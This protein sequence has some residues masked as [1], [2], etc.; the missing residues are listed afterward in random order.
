MSGSP[1]D[2]SA[3]AGQGDP[4]DR[5]S[6]RIEGLGAL[7]WLTRVR[8]RAGVR[9]RL[10]QMRS[11]KR[12]LLTVLGVAF[13]GLA[14]AAQVAARDARVS[15]DFVPLLA[16]AFLVAFPCLMAWQ[17][18]RQGVIHFK[19]EE[20]Q[21]L[22]PAPI[23][24]RALVVMN[25]LNRLGRVL[26]LSL[27]I[28]FFA[29]P[30]G[31]GYLQAA[32]CYSLLLSTASVMQIW[33]DVRLIG[34]PAEVRRR[35]SNWLG[36]L[37][38]LG[39]AASIFAA[40]HADDRVV[41]PQILR[42][43]VAPAAPFVAILTGR[44]PLAHPGAL[45]ALSAV[46]ALL[47]FAAT[48]VRV[49]IREA[50]HATSARMQRKLSRLAK[51][52]LAGAPRASTSGRLLPMP[53]HLGGAGPHIWRQLTALSRSKRP[54]VSIIIFAIYMAVVLF[55][56]RGGE[57]DAVTLARF[58]AIIG[59][60]MVTMTGPMYIQADF[61][62]DYDL[63]PW[64]R[65]LPTP[66]GWLAAGQL[67]GSVLVMFAL[68]LLLGGWILFVVPASEIPRWLGALAVLPAFDLILLS[69]WNGAFLL[70]PVRMTNPGKMMG[71]GQ[72]MRMYL[73]FFV[74]MLVVL[75]AVAVAAVMGLAAGWIA[76]AAS[77]QALAGY[78]AG[79][80]V[81]YAA[82]VAV[83]AVCVWLVGRIF[84]RVDPSRDLIA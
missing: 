76:R 71:F 22:F 12:A 80:I 4:A 21:F 83:A 74:V 72:A 7:W 16:G 17:A 45:A 49:D 27:A 25:V 52:S 47:V 28:S 10:H 60:G 24:T 44:T 14:I 66:P 63:L 6:Q 53:P 56:T 81:G 77:G 75:A 20:I 34:L 37:L 78:V 13:F 2:P 5:P 82:L 15:T 9:R 11:P 79:G 55:F 84:I 58:G 29:R 3:A 26:G 23:T 51:G 36:L 68:Q 38:L 57:H 65:T 1:H 59:L 30:V 43:F 67:L 61:R 31:V 19:P 48:R 35:R 50:A 64:L 62:S 32:L 33:I 46:L 8:L 40:W 42:Y 18:T 54:F 70:Y 73:V 39:I 41:S 69:V